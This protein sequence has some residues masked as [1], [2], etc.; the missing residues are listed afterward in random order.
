MLQGV[1]GGVGG[2]VVEEVKGRGKEE[3]R[4]ETL[5]KF[6]DE[7][8]H[9]LSHFTWTYLLVLIPEIGY[10][11]AMLV[12]IFQAVHSVVVI[13][14]KWP[15]PSIQKILLGLC[16]VSNTSSID[17]NSNNHAQIIYALLVSNSTHKTAKLRKADSLLIE[18][19]Q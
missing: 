13:Q 14:R 8:T 10:S 6:L 19:M 7:T 12:L 9:W 16:I 18:S 11:M 4:I 15:Y 5:T 1:D 2:N 17:N 3:G